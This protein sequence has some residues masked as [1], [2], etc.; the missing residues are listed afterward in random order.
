MATLL[1]RY[2]NADK[3]ATPQLTNTISKY[4]S[5]IFFLSI[6]VLYTLKEVYIYLLSIP[7]MDL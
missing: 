2:R 1:S 5:T 3:I 4:K 7:S 6:H